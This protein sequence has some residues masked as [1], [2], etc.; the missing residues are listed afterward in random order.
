MHKSVVLEYSNPATWYWYELECLGMPAFINDES[1]NQLLSNI[2]LWPEAK[3]ISTYICKLICKLNF[4]NESLHL[5]IAR[6]REQSSSYDQDQIRHELGA[7][8]AEPKMATW[9]QIDKPPHSMHW[10]SAIENWGCKSLGLSMATQTTLN[11]EKPPSNLP[12]NHLK[13]SNT[14][15]KYR[16]LRCV[17]ID[18]RVAYRFTN[19]LPK[20]TSKTEFIHKRWESRKQVAVTQKNI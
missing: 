11:H 5:P 7:G 20:L 15:V 8:C 14:A 1:W 17:L 13:S 4:I 2:T 12:S 6:I 16:F 9:A 19:A 3:S 10:P 18:S